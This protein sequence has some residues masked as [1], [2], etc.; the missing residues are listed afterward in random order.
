MPTRA[1]CDQHVGVARKA[2]SGD[3]LQRHLPQAGQFHG[4]HRRLSP[5][6]A[7]AP[8]RVA[9]AEFVAERERVGVLVD[10]QRLD[11]DQFRPVNHLLG[12]EGQRE[13][14]VVRAAR[15]YPRLGGHAQRRLRLP[16]DARDG[17]FRHGFAAA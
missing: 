5:Q 17:Q 3:I 14:G 10:Q 7:Q 11:A 9:P 13:A 16:Q 6:P 12:G 1:I 8:G 2:G 15:Q 4:L